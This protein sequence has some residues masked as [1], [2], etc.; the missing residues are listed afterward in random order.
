MTDFYSSLGVSAEKGEVHAAIK[1]QSAGVFPG[2]FCKVLDDVAGD[3]D[4][5]C[6]LHADGAG[7]KSALAYLYWKETGDATVFEDLA[8]DALMMN[9][10]DL[11]CIGA[12]DHF[13]LSNTIGR[14][15]KNI[16]GDVIAR[17][18]DGYDRAIA[19]LEKQGVRVTSCGGET[20][21]VGDL[22]QTLIVDSTVF[23]RLPRKDVID[24]DNIRAG[25]VIVGFASFGKAPFERRYNAGMGS[26]GLTAA[27]HLLLADKYRE[28]YPETY[29]PFSPRENVYCGKFCVT[30]PL[31]DTG[32]NI[33][34]A[35]LSPTRPYVG[36]IRALLA[37]LGRADVHGMIHCTGGGQTKCRK[38]GRG[39]HYVKDALFDIPPLFALLC[40]R[41]GNMREAFMD[42]NMGHR[43]EL[44][45]PQQ[46]AEEALSVARDFGI[47]AKII[48]RVEDCADGQNHVTIRHDGQT[49][50]Y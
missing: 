43:L 17:V 19:M 16:P 41:L 44:F 46:T 10:D 5:C 39:V 9:I 48:G 33:G 34:Q 23:C 49:Y 38:F 12:T 27:R 45:C 32:V 42:F 30:D 36:L 25:D 8:Q 11:A 37:T 6:A 28:L 2:A 20:A 7:T 40:E 22:T 50:T 35:I 31:A 14:S 29:S 3:A 21:D 15:A 18:I 4:F 26:N 47:E 13:L 24:C 1:N